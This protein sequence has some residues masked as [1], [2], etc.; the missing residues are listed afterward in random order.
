MKYLFRTTP[1]L[2]KGDRTLLRYTH[3]FNIAAFVYVSGTEKILHD[4][5]KLIT[6][7]RVIALKTCRH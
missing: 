6:E 1:P 7:L 4:L 2:R 3:S 5:F